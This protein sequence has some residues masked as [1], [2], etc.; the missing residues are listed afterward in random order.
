MYE[1]PRTKKSVYSWANVCIELRSRSRQRLNSIVDLNRIKQFEESS[2]RNGSFSSTNRVYFI[3]TF[4]FIHHSIF[5]EYHCHVCKALESDKMAIAY[6][7]S[8][9][10]LSGLDWIVQRPHVWHL[11]I[12]TN[13]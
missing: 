8:T 10:Q 6:D 5:I 4:F 11:D 13:E 1:T 2:R 9:H 3:E 7:P 12:I